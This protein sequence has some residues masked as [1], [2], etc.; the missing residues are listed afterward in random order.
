MKGMSC[1]GR[2]STD[3][4]IFIEA[5]SADAPRRNKVHDSTSVDWKENL[6]IFILYYVW[7]EK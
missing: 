2:T 5:A 4:Q 1:V 3:G 7:Y 6:L